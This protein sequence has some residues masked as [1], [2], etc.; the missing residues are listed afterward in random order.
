MNNMLKKFLVLISIFW[1]LTITPLSGLSLETLDHVSTLPHA[2]RASASIGVVLI[3]AGNFDYP[4]ATFQSTFWIW[5]TSGNPNADALTNLDIR[6]ATNL[7]II[8]DLMSTNKGKYWHL[9]KIK[10]TFR[11]YWDLSKYPF[12]RQKL[13]IYI[14]EGELSSDKFIYLVDNESKSYFHSPNLKGWKLEAMK[15]EVGTT[16]YESNFGDPSL[17]DLESSSFASAEI[18]VDLS[19]SSQSSFWRITAGAF[20]SLSL[21]LSSFLLSYKNI[22]HLNA[23]L[24]LLGASAYANVISIRNVSSWQGPVP[25]IT[26]IDQIHMVPMLAI[27]IGLVVTLCNLRIYNKTLSVDKCDAIDKYSFLALTSLTVFSLA[28]I[29]LRIRF[30]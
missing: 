1:I 6:N 16:Q 19:R 10:G 8:T 9:Q 2:N 26:F 20:I 12:D 18:T 21:V 22:G 3:D 27:L 15:I 25:Y 7:E 23:R 11:N 28:T 17:N 29:L 24:G 13:K 30:S 4:N 5:S 14:E